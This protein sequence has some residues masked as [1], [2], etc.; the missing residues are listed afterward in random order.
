MTEN[1]VEKA[2][3]KEH[4]V[5]TLENEENQQSM[6]S[7]DKLKEFFNESK[8]G[9]YLFK[10]GKILLPFIVLIVL[11]EIIF[12][13]INATVPTLGSNILPP[14]HLIIV[15]AWESFFTDS[16]ENSLI[17]DIGISLL[18]VI[19]GFTVG[20]L[21]GIIIG[22]MMGLS[23]I[24]FKLLNPIFSL[25]ISIPTLAW[26]PILLIIFGFNNTTI[27]VTIVLSCF[28][29]VVYSTTNG[30]RSIDRNLIWAAR[31]MGASGL[32]IFFDVYLPGSLVSLITGLRLG[33]GYSWRAIVGAE[34]LTSFEYGIGTYIYGGRFSADIAQVLVGIILIAICGLLLDAILMKP[35]EILTIKKWGMIEKSKRTAEA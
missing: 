13:I 22:I 12:V 19:I 32:D 23:N 8:Y 17:K 16:I 9:K 29:P 14:P 18:K 15:R 28:F 11:T 27:V 34:I 1:G 10:I 21:A 3:K 5:L 20:S 26:V 33:I 2:D 30:I 6:K 31:I 7:L 25:L 24:L 35:L 4:K